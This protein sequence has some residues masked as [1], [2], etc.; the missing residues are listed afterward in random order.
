M[1]KDHFATKLLPND[2]DVKSIK[3]IKIKLIYAMLVL[4]FDVKK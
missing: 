4:C 1:I 3:L 2:H